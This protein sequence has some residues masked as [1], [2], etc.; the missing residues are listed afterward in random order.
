MAGETW[1]YGGRIAVDE[2]AYFSEPAICRTRGGRILVLLR[3]HLRR[4]DS[5]QCQLVL[6]TSDDDGDSWSPWRFTSMKGCP[7]TC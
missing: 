6:V 3:C 1:E 7:R 5:T 4:A 2:V